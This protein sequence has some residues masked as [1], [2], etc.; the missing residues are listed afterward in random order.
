[1]CVM[2]RFVYSFVWL[3]GLPSRSEEKYWGNG[4][5]GDSLRNILIFWHSTHSAYAGHNHTKKKKKSFFSFHFSILTFFKKLKRQSRKIMNIKEKQVVGGEGRYQGKEGIWGGWGVTGA[6]KTVWRERGSHDASSFPTP[7]SFTEVPPLH[8]RSGWNNC[9]VFDI[10]HWTLEGEGFLG[11]AFVCGEVWS[12][13][14]ESLRRRSRE[15][16]RTGLLSL[17]PNQTTPLPP[18]NP[19][20][21]LFTLGWCGTHRLSRLP[22]EDGEQLTE[23]T[24]T[25]HQGQAGARITG[26]QELDCSLLSSAVTTDFF[27]LMPIKHNRTHCAESTFEVIVQSQQPFALSLLVKAA[28]CCW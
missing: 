10:I 12:G 24:A 20:V 21:C 9:G 14:E 2:L 26:L 6:N 7:V 22:R 4:G 28:E 27:C 15:G 5:G 23:N 8:T 17:T 1:M 19:T 3:A 25:F 11:W 16:R 18:F 13:W